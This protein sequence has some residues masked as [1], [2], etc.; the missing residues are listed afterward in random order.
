MTNKKAKGKRAKTR[1]LFKRKKGKLSVNK[2]LKSIPIDSTIQIN[3]DSSVHSGMP[4]KRFHSLTGKVIGK[5]KKVF[6]V[7]VLVGKTLKELLVHPAHL[8][9]LNQKTAAE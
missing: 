3:L 8:K 1:R 7:K 2:L 6:K 4:H 5:Q 9:V